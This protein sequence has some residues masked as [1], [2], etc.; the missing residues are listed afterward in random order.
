MKKK[1][2]GDVANAVNF[3]VG[4]F[5]ELKFCWWIGFIGGGVMPSAE[6]S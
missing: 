6:G 4:G 2:F 5:V 1:M 3:G